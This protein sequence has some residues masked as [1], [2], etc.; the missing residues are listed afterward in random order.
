MFS[1]ELFLAAHGKTLT[2][3]ATLHIPNMPTFTSSLV[4][5]GRVLQ[6]NMFYK[7]D[8]HREG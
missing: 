8:R 7:P 2:H 5:V 3:F 4:R 6:K 1:L